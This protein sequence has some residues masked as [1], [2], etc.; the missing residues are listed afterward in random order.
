MAI[1]HRPD[2]EDTLGELVNRLPGSS[3]VLESFGI[4]YCCGGRRTLDEAC[5][6]LGVAAADVAAALAALGPGEAPEWAHLDP[7]ALVDHLEST[8]HAYLHAELPRLDALAAKVA[9]VHGARHPELIEVLADVKDLADDLEPHL[10]KEERVLFPMIRELSVA[11]GPVAT[12][13]GSVRRPVAVMMAEHETTGR[14]LERL[15]AH[16]GG[17]SVPADGC[18]SYRALYEGLAELEADTHL[19]VHKENNV[20]F[21]A[22]VAM[23]GELGA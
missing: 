8:H 20:L 23:E 4:D 5:A 19:H 7:G 18:A 12:H 21:P 15:R 6:E 22:V 13:C 16:T 17:F 11:D 2:V 14:L 1:A 10:M 3:R 9:S